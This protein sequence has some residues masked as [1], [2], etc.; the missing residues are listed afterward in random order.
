MRAL[1]FLMF[2]PEHK[3]NPKRLQE[4]M[5]INALKIKGELTA[6][7]FIRPMSKI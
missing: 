6:S 1:N 4:E 5:S 2:Y 3:C 7:N